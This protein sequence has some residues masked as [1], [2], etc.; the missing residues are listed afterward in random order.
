MEVSLD[1]DIVTVKNKENE[2]KI[3]SND[4]IPNTE[5]PLLNALSSISNE[6]EA[7]SS[8]NIV[9]PEIIDYEDILVQS[10][11]HKPFISL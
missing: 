2:S 3:E 11:I 6:E 7:L 10:K 9:T 4:H 8:R 5:S 1:P